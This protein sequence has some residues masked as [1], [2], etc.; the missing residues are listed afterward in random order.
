MDIDNSILERIKILE[1][2]DTMDLP[3]NLLQETKK[4]KNEDGS[5]KIEHSIMSSKEA[6]PEEKRVWINLLF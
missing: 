4:E 2:V 6:S 5:D 1:T 3:Y